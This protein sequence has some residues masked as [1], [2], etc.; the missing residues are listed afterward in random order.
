MTVIETICATI[1]PR[2]ITVIVGAAACSIRSVVRVYITVVSVVWLVKIVVRVI[3]IICIVIISVVRITVMRVVWPR[4]GGVVRSVGA[5]IG[6]IIGCS[7]KDKFI[8][9]DL[10]Q[11]T[12]FVSPRPKQS[13]GQIHHFEDAFHSKTLATLHLELH[14][15]QQDLSP[16]YYAARLTTL[17]RG[18]SVTFTYKFLVKVLALYPLED[19][20]P[21]RA[22]CD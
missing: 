9:G 11:I 7:V 14:R 12:V 6:R 19:R 2:A 10:G 16:F 5:Q 18:H 3:R 8:C 15:R 13:T 21:R 1:T 17:A 20:R 22:M 4:R